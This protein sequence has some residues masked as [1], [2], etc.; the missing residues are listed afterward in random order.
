MHRVL[1]ACLFAA[2]IPAAHAV[3]P[4]GGFP[5]MPTTASAGQTVLVPAWNW[6]EAGAGPQAA[7]TGFVWY[8][9]TLVQPG[10]THSQVQY[11]RDVQSVPNSYIVPIAPG[12][13]A[14][15]G[16]IVLTW[17]QSG[18]GMQRAI[19]VAADDPAR[20]VV[21]YLD[22][23]WDNPAKSRDKST[24][25]GKMDEALAADSFMP[26]LP[27]APGSIFRCSD[28]G[29][30]VRR[31]LIARADDGRS[32]M[33][34]HAGLLAIHAD[35]DCTPTPLRPD[36]AAGD[37]PWVEFA[38]TFVQAKVVRVEPAIGR[39]FVEQF[40]KERAIAFGDVMP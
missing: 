8:H 31:Q 1:A 16:D 5:D 32:L 9:Q 29:K 2:A 36:V 27:G 4:F 38:G 22:I 34:T 18:S 23:A 11:M 40:G 26:L 30:P 15:V 6:I 17:W 19:V 21:R 12:A 13:R 35:G 24:T 39:V 37:M 28:N 3:A 33:R 7:R 25:I 20:P 14:A 10:A